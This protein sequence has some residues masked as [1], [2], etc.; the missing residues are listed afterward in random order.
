M[1]VVTFQDSE[2]TCL[3]SRMEAGREEIRVRA[4]T[5]TH[6]KSTGKDA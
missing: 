5:Q 3:E 2:S 6:P 4:D 1:V